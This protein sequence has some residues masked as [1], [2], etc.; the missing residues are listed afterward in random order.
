MIRLKDLL[1][2][3]GYVSSQG[4]IVKGK[5]ATPV[6]DTISYLTS[7]GGKVLFLTTSTR[8]PFNTG[9]GKGNLEVEIPKSTELALYIK[10]NI[11]NESH[12]IDIPQLNILP[13]EGNVSAKDG[14]NCGVEA[15]KLKNKE[16]N[17]TGNHRCWASFN[18]SSDELWKVSKKLFE[19]DTV[20]FFTSIRWGQTAA[21][22]QKLIERL[23]WI[24]NRHE[25]LKDENVIKGKKAGF[26]CIGHNYGGAE[27]SHLQSL[28][29]SHFGFDAPENLFWNWQ[30]TD[31][32]DESLESYSKAHSKFHNDMGIPHIETEEKK[33]D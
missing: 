11:P 29:L 17:P 8:Y 23:T 26:I 24:Q 13:C 4:E 30:Y 16:K 6:R 22:Y 12:W 9:Y 7:N 15:A 32:L 10:D 19:C 5:L 2:E 18:N 28:V 27:I 31:W 3:D 21:M 1:N 25:T 20:M 33:G 14:N